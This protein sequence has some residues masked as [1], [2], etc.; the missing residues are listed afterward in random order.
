MARWAVV[1]VILAVACSGTSS[2][3]TMNSPRSETTALAPSTTESAPDTTPPA[4][5]T[6]KAALVDVEA[7]CGVLDAE[8]YIVRKEAV[9]G[10]EDLEPVRSTCGAELTVLEEAMAVEAARASVEESGDV[11]SLDPVFEC[12]AS[13][14]SLGVTNTFDWP[15][16]LYANGSLTPAEGEEG[17][18]WDSNTPQVVW[19]IEVGETVTLAGQFPDHDETRPGCSLVGYTFL[20]DDPA[21]PGDAGIPGVEL[22]DGDDA[23]LWI[24]DVFTRESR[25]EDEG[26][27]PVLVAG[28]E[29]LRSFAYSR[30]TALEEPRAFL[31]EG[32]E[33]VAVCQI[34][35][36]PDDDHVSLIYR[37]NPD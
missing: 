12:S 2:S 30:L 37:A 24:Q 28:Y 18:V 11:T 6:T 15:I 19:R 22:N 8:P 25:F 5:T 27:D 7:L 1:M 35:S 26:S 13:T 16:G 29:D 32:T 17:A 34:V 31:V 36:R 23:T 10:I 4:T 21:L 33:D 20:A 9:A 3:S 14:W